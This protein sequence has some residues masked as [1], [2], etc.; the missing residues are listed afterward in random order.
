MRDSPSIPLV[1]DLVR[2]GA[3]VRA[4]DPVAMDNA[5]DVLPD[6]VVFCDDAYDAATGADAV[7]IVTEW[8]QFRS[9][10]LDRLR[11]AMR[12]HVVV[13]L[14][15]VY[16]P[17]KMRSRGFRYDSMGRAASDLPPA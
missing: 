12:D 15:N 10:D 3:T 9:L 5:R 6:A 8:N 14:R 13:D 7:V 1:D 17:G 11:E 16:E 2:A 4:F